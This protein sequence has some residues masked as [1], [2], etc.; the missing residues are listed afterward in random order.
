[1]IRIAAYKLHEM[2]QIN[3]AVSLFEKVIAKFIQ[4][5]QQQIR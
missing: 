4:V 1:M 3:E 2:G 5:I